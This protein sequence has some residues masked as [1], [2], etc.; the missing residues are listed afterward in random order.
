[1]AD[2]NVNILSPIQNYE[3]GLISAT[4]EEQYYNSSNQQVKI[5]LN[6]FS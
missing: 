2:Y 1:M 4:E 3:D 6:K 5:L